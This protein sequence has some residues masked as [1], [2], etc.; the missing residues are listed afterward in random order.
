MDARR[1]A[2]L[3]LAAPVA[4]QPQAARVTAGD[5]AGQG[6][7]LDSWLDI[8]GRP[9]ARVMINGRGPFSF[10]VDTGSTTTVIAARHVA[11]LEARPRGRVTVI[12]ATGSAVMPLVELASLEAGVV[13]KRIFLSRCC[14]MRG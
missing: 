2:G 13:E 7:V 4:A 12:G 5:Q 1:A 14:R 11:A 6:Y 8:H 9:T 3:G 10:M